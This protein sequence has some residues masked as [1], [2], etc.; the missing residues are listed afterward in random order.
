MFLKDFVLMVQIMQY[1]TESYE[2]TFPAKTN[3]V[4]LKP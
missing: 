3:I 2:K 4:G 1:A